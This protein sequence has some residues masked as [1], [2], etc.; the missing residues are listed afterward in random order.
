MMRSLTGW[1]GWRG[2]GVLEAWGRV[3]RMRRAS[4]EDWKDVRAREKV[5]TREFGCGRGMLASCAGCGESVVVLM[6][7]YRGELIIDEK[8]KFKDKADV[9][10]TGTTIN[11]E[12]AT[13]ITAY[14][15]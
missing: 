6:M 10:H 14:S 8:P 15:Y 11:H 13:T 4:D 12:A 2:A 7:L 9:G 5:V 1:D 3:Q